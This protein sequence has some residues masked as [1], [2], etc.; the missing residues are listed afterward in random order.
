MQFP[1]LVLECRQ[2]TRRKATESSA[3][4]ARES[5]PISS[6]FHHFWT[7]SETDDH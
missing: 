5:N 4:S 6:Q 1:L 2:I 3:T 7:L